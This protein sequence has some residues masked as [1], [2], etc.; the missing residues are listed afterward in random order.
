MTWITWLN[1]SWRGLLNEK[2]VMAGVCCSKALEASKMAMSKKARKALDEG[3]AS[4]KKTIAEG[5]TFETYAQI[6]ERHKLN[7]EMRAIVAKSKKAAK[8][9]TVEDDYPPHVSKM[10]HS[11]NA[12]AEEG[13]EVK[14]VDPPY[15]EL[16]SRCTELENKNQQIIAVLKMMARIMAV[17]PHASNSE[18]WSLQIFVDELAK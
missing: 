2:E 16:M 3:L 18:Y 1:K 4:A 9:G 13:T 10:F 7:K 8:K 11:M 6:Q 17:T 5:G 15:V 12:V 14:R